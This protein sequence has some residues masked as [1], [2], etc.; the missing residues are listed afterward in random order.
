[1]SSFQ[2]TPIRYEIEIEAWR[3]KFKTWRETTWTSPS[4]LHLGHFK[5]LVV[6]PYQWK[7]DHCKRNS[8]MESYQQELL[9]STLCIVN[10]A[11]KSGNILDCW[12][13]ATNI[14]IPK[15]NGS[16]K[17]TDYRNIH[18]YECDMNAVLSLKWKEALKQ[19]E[20]QNVICPSQGGSRKQKSSQF[21]IHIEISQ[22]EISRL[23]QKE[24]GQINYDSKAFY[25]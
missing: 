6:I 9:E 7:N 1:M 13:N 5:S 23:T 10:F 11:I 2:T 17:V 19:S 12:I 21:S 22:L 3:Q 18:I 25:D 15:K 4:R 24:Y 16:Y 14:M 8:L 20:D